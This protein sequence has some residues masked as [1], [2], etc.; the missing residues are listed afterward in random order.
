MWDYEKVVSTILTSNPYEVLINEIR[1]AD[2][3]K[4]FGNKFVTQEWNAL[5]FTKAYT[6]KR[7]GRCSD[8]SCYLI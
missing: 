1:K 3:I 8:E 4:C 5:C 7:L 6:Y 2:D